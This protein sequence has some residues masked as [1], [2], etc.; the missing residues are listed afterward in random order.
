MK[1]SSPT[2][3]NEKKPIAEL[4]HND[5]LSVYMPHFA[6][7]PTSCEIWTEFSHVQSEWSANGVV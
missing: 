3:Q 6:L 4:G 5:L 2:I 7:M 1:S